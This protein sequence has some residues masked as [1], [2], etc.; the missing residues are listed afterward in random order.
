VARPV[1]EAAP[2]V[3]EGQRA[4]VAPSGAAEPCAEAEPRAE[5]PSAGAEPVGLRG[6]DAAP[7]G[8]VRRAAALPEVAEPADGRLAAV[9]IAAVLPATARLPGAAEPQPVSAQLQARPALK[10]RPD[11]DVRVPDARAHRH[12]GHGRD[13]GHRAVPVIRDGHPP[14][15]RTA[16]RL[17]PS[18]QDRGRDRMA[19]AVL[20]W[21]PEPAGCCPSAVRGS[22]VRPVRRSQAGSV[23]PAPA[24]RRKAASPAAPAM[25]NRD[26]ARHEDRAGLAA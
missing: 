10:R 15:G 22:P 17:A 5:A 8:V 21:L 19:P 7:S 1:L 11:H 2:C 9:R 4:V 3:A 23:P 18:R 12:R 16:P 14:P 25:S 20:P 24:E 26:R 13:A 6:P